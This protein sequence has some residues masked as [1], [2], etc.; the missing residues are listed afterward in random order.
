[1]LHAAINANTLTT[2]SVSIAP[3]ATVFACDSI[4]II[5]DVVPELMSE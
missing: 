2:L 3:T 5:L 4:I 1:M